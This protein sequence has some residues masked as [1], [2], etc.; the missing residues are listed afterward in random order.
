MPPVRVPEKVTDGAGAGTSE[1]SV[2]GMVVSRV[3]AGEAAA[4]FSTI[5]PAWSPGCAGVGTV[6]VT[7]A[8]VLGASVTELVDRLPKFCQVAVLAWN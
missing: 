3:N 1:R 5:S 4:L 7:L 6:S 2:T 8:D